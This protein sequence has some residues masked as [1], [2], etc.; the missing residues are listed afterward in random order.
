MK[1]GGVTQ[2]ITTNIEK[3][4]TNFPNEGFGFDQF[5]MFKEGDKVTIT[6]SLLSCNYPQ[7]FYKLT[8][9]AKL[10][11]ILSLKATA[12][13]FFKSNL[14]NNFKKAADIYQ[15]INGYYNFGDSTNNY[16][17]QDETDPDFVKDY[18]EL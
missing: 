4:H 7:Y 10:Y 18:S 3:L 14:N 15:K 11:H 6:I 2:V 5:T 16:A 13:R 1:K 12:T 8:V 17:K 9:A